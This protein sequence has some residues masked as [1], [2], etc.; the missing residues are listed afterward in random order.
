MTYGAGAL[1]VAV[2]LGFVPEGYPEVP[3]G[4]GYEPFAWANDA[5]WDALEDRYAD[6]S[7]TCPSASEHAR[8]LGEVERLAIDQPGPEDP[9]WQTA[10]QGVFTLAVGYARCPDRVEELVELRRRL[11][12]AAKDASVRWPDDVASRRRLYRTLYGPRAAAEEVFLQLPPGSGSSLSL[13]REVPSQTPSTTV[14]GVEIHSGDLLLSR[15]GAPTS[16]FIARG[17]DYPG[18]FSHVA[19]VHVDETSGEASVIESHIERGVVVATPAQYLADKKLRILVLRMRPDH[20]ALVADPMLPHAAASAAK[21][22]TLARHIPYDFAMDFADPEK[23][24]CSEV[25]SH[26]Y[27]EQGVTLWSRLTA[28][29]SPGLARWMAGFGVRK[30]ETHGPSD[31]E[32]DPALQVV[33]EWHDPDILFDDHVDNAVIDALLERADEGLELDHD[34]L[35][36]PLARLA[37]AY[38]VIVEAFGGE[39]PVPEGMSATVALRAQWLEGTHAA[40]KAEVLEAAEAFE[41]E[42]GYRPPYWELVRMAREASGRVLS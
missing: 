19:L 5:M 39:G 9:R 4:P 30:L 41:R 26:A 3:E 27:G 21:S 13:G 36:L 35:L 8:V 20:P 17:N 31:L 24:F 37:K 23:Q 12:I 42:R 16:A 1:A 25:A 11:R 10:E 40:I 18:N 29:S 33:A 28:F 14:E 32:Y 38:S 22:E 6:A 7:A 15:G 2:G 34:A